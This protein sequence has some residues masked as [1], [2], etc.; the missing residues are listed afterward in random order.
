MNP[1]YLTGFM[2]SGKTTVG[3]ALA[4]EL[5]LPVVDTDTY[6]EKMTGRRI[7][8]IFAEQGETGFRRLE[9]QAL[10]AVTKE[11][12][13]ITTGGGIVLSRENREFMKKRGTVVHL[14]CTAEEIMRRLANDQDRPLLRGKDME[15]VQRMYAD[16]LPLYEQCDLEIDTTGASVETIVRRCCAR[17]ITRSE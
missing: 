1:V 12:T 17:L 2:G 5:G 10:K 9:T 15:S 4:A 7:K 11:N 6:I 8:E 13:V 16:R 14:R 3:K